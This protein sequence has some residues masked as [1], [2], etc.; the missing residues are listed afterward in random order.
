MKSWLAIFF[1]VV[2][3]CATASFAIDPP[4]PYAGKSTTVK[5]VPI[6]PAPPKAP[7]RETRMRATGKVIEI[8][9]EAVKIER[10]V[11]GTVETMDFSLVKP[12]DKIKVGDEVGVSYIA[13]DN[14]N[15]AKR[16]SKVTKKKVAPPN[17]AKTAINIP[18]R[19]PGKQ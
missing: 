18:P 12:L 2:F 19:T 9:P 17:G 14:Q 3:I 7:P 1:C 5:T 16:I 4:D 8:S 13:K 11:K 6:K 10:N 15:I